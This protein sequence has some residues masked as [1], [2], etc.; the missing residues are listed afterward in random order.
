MAWRMPL[1]GRD[2]DDDVAAA[3]WDLRRSDLKVRVI[4][5]VLGMTVLLKLLLLLLLWGVVVVVVVVVAAIF[6]SLLVVGG[7]AIKNE[8][9]GQ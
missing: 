7:A 3:N 2:E 1:Q 8:N 9:N 6:L 5:C 4:F